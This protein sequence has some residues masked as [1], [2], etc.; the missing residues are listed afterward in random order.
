[1][2]VGVGLIASP[3]GPNVFVVSA[4]A[5]DV[6]PTSSESACSSPSPGLALWLVRLLS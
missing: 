3:I 6:L 1:M 4:I 2:V 5:K